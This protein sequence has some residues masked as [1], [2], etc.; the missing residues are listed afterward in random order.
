[1]TKINAFAAAVA[2]LALLSTSAMAATTVGTYG[3][4]SANGDVTAPPGGGA[5]NYVTTAGGVSGG[6]QIAGVGGTTGSSWTSD[7]FTAAAGD[8]LS[9]SFN[10]VTSDGAG[11]SDY[12][13]AALLDSSQSVV[14]YLFTARTTPSGNTSPGFGLPANSATLNP[15]A[16]PIIANQT[17]WS[18]LGADSGKCYSG[19]CG[20]TGWITS[21]Y[22]IVT[23]GT[24]S[25][26]FG[27]TNTV[28]SGYQSG[29]AWSG[30]RVGDTVIPDDTVSTVPV[31]ATLPLLAGAL[32]LPAFLRRK[33]R[34]A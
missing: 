3:T 20:M 24:Y 11:F 15:G 26:T 27:V 14:A 33:A 22:E 10:Y 16:T 2:G 23:A 25:L 29:L 21:T 4:A 7:A 6:G 13:W 19:G 18:A 31:P 9:F 34:K 5:Y 1:M 8:I 32:G 17:D 28:D 30:A 12:G